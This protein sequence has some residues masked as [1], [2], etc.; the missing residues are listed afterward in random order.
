MLGAAVADDVLG[1][2]LLTI[3]VKV[4]TSGSVDILDVLSIIAVAL[5]F[6]VD[7]G[8]SRALGFGPA[9]LRFDRALL[10]LARARSWRSP[11]RSRW[12]SRLLADAA[13]LAPIV[14]AFA[15]GVALSG[16]APAERVRRELAPVGHLFIPVFFLQ[17]GVHADLDGLTRPEDARAS[18][19]CS[20]S[21]LRSASWSPASGCSAESATASPSGS[22]CSPAAKSA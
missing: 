9:C 11:S 14:G 20:C 15:A 21:W 17:I 10:A 8:R 19:P 16:S 22:A 2:I 13:E 5:A 18:S 12:C 3:V 7:L 6:L 4:V 1:L